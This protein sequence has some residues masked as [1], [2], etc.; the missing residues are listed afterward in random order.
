M[1]RKSHVEQWRSLRRRTVVVNGKD[2]PLVK[3]LEIHA[4]HSCNLSCLSCSHYSDQNHKGIISPETAEEWM[5]PWTH[6]LRTDKL[7]ILGGEPL[8]NKRLPEFL[9]ICRGLWPDPKIVLTTNGFLAKTFG[10]ELPRALA[11]TETLVNISIHH[12][13]EE[14]MERF[15]EQKHIFRRWEDTFGITVT[16]RQS[17]N[18][19]AGISE[20]WTRRYKGKGTSFRPFEDNNPRKSWVYCAAK[21]CMQVFEGELWKCPAI[22]YLRMQC[23][24]YGVSEHWEPYLKYKG[25]DINCSD[26]KL[27]EWLRKEEEP[28]CKMCPAK[29]APLQLP[30][31]LKSDPS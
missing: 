24:K 26:E 30:N 11:A 2:I 13:G 12:N 16:Y 31:P 23:E 15:N 4:A 17:V 10:D 18:P 28:I 14:Y 25:L 3:N 7:S 29:P 1:S 22:A 8:I 19:T 20:G 27:I 9:K 21:G 6:R 5:E